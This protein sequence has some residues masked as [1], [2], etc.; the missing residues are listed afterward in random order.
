MPDTPNLIRAT[1]NLPQVL[2]AQPLPSVSAEIY[3]GP[4]NKSTAIG[5]VTLCNTSASTR[6]A[7]ILVSKNLGGTAKLAAIEL[8]VGESCVVDELVG[9]FLGPGDAILGYASAGSSVD[10]AISGAVSS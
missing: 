3:V 8:E 5:T 7:H 9:F 6:T 1:S 4:A 2:V 10:I